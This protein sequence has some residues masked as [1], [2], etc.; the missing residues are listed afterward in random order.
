MT[1]ATKTNNPGTSQRE[2]RTYSFACHRSRQDIPPPYREEHAVQ[3]ADPCDRPH[4][5]AYHDMLA[6]FD[7]AVAVFAHEYK[8]LDELDAGRHLAAINSG[9]IE[10]IDNVD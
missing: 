7:H 8:D 2:L 4:Y 5:P 10:A 6:E 3:N 1:I 9:R